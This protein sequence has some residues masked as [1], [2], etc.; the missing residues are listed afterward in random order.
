MFKDILKEMRVK[1]YTKNILVY[2]AAL[3]SGN[4]Y[5]SVIFVRSSCAFIAFSAMASVVYILNDIMDKEKDR[6]HPTKSRRPIASGRICVPLAI[7]GAIVLT[8]ISLTL[9]WYINYQ[10]SILLIV[11]FIINVA[12]S[13]KL[14]HIVIIDV[15]I[16][17][18]GFVLR[19]FAGSVAIDSGATSWFILCVFM[20]SLFLAL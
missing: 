17:A 16:V 8:I 14:K 19:A 2:A 13:I 6:M 20:L 18:F 5:N 10:L 1:Q 9:S 3:F 11:Y 12:Y 15:M 4:V 7:G